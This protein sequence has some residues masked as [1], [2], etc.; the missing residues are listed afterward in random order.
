MF[1][2]KLIGGACT[3]SY[4]LNVARLARLPQDVLNKARLKSKEFEE[5]MISVAKE[6]LMSGIL[7]LVD[8]IKE[9]GLT[10]SLEKKLI[11]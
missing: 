7:R 3:K 9:N 1:L 5:T 8:E 2:Y 11:T 6:S 10:P 4:G